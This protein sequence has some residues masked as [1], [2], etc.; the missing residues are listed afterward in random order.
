MTASVPAGHT[1]TVNFNA[2]SLVILTPVFICEAYDP[3]SGN[4]Q[5]PW[6]EFRGIWDTGASHSVITSKVVKSVNI[7]QTGQAIVNTA[8]GKTSAGRYLVNIRLLNGVAFPGIQVTHGDLGDDVDVLIGMD[9]ITLGDFSITNVDGKTCMSF[10]VPSTKKI[11]YVE[12]QRFANAEA[13][14]H[15]KGFDKQEAT[16]KRL[17]EK[18][19]QQNKNSNH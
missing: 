1:L 19:S 2:R 4:P 3:N 18:M 12:E 10:R 16:R 13:E 17:L 8:N 15:L 11:D 9:I 5:P 14:K 6:H 7:A